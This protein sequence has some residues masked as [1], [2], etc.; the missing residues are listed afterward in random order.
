ME[1]MLRLVIAPRALVRTLFTAMFLQRCVHCERL[2]AIVTPMFAILRVQC[3]VIR[4]LVAELETLS[5]VRASVW[6]RVAMHGHV[7]PHCE[8][9]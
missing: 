9:E 7:F 4:Q 5:A 8:S 1:D 6:A 3:H 2:A